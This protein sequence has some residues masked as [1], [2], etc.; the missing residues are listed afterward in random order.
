MGGTLIAL[1]WADALLAIIYIM[2]LVVALWIGA[3]ATAPKR[4]R[5]DARLLCSKLQ[6]ELNDLESRRPNLEVSFERVIYGGR[7]SEEE[8][9][10]VAEV[11]VINKG[12]QPSVFSIKDFVYKDKNG[13]RESKLF[14]APQITMQTTSD[15]PALRYNEE[16][17]LYNKDDT[18]I[19]EGARVRGHIAAAIKGGSPDDKTLASVTLDLEDITGKISSVTWEAEN[20]KNQGLAYRKGVEI[21]PAEQPEEGSSKG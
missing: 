19:H 12:S 16:N 10:F 15:A 6:D 4:Q 17:A 1:I 20:T 3:T 8:F 14:H 18:P 13:V 21:V 5:D 9:V 7:I 2:G 11:Q